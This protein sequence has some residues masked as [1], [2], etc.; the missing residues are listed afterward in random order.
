MLHSRIPGVWE[1]VFRPPFSTFPFQ[2]ITKNVLVKVSRGK[3][4]SSFCIK[5]VKLVEKNTFW[6]GVED[7]ILCYSQRETKKKYVF[8]QK[9]TF[10]AFP[11]ILE[12]GVRSLVIKQCQFLN[13]LEWQSTAIWNLVLHLPWLALLYL[14]SE[15]WS[16]EPSFSEY[17]R[18]ITARMNQTFVIVFTNV[19]GGPN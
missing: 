8:L 1:P 11:E 19:I 7:S 6:G 4:S 2:Y 17:V 16:V 12:G 9:E 13:P 10:S 5:A 15:I 18:A 3:A 14:L